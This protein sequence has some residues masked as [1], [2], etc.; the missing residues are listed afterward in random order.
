MIVL[1]HFTDGSTQDVTRWAKYTAADTTVATVDDP[2][3]KVK[4]IGNGEGRDH[5]LVP[6]QDRHRHGRVAV[7]RAASPADAFTKPRRANFIDELVLEKLASL[8]LPPSPAARDAEF[9]RRAFLDT[10]GVL[11]TADETTRVPRRSP[12]PTSATS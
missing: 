7:S 12:R 1:A 3:G 9:L 6:Q 11:P 5:R 8:N 10:I 2:T 4:V